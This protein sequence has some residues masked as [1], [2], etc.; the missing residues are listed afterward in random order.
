MPKDEYGDIFFDGNNL[1]DENSQKLK[2]A[3]ELMMHWIH[4]MFK[5]GNE[6]EL[7]KTCKDLMKKHIKYDKSI[8]V[9]SDSVDGFLA[10][11]DLK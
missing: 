11:Q 10:N 9:Q 7:Q 1:D 3:G 2:K 6:P 8:Q 5:N 4:Q